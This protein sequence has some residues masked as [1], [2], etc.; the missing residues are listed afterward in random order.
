MRDPSLHIKK[1]DLIKVLN[2]VKYS[3]RTTGKKLVDEIFIQSQRYQ[4]KDRYLEVLDNKS[5][6]RKKMS[7]S[8]ESD[9]GAP[10][11][12][13]ETFNRSLVTVLMEDNMYRKQDLVTKGHKD[14]ILLKEIAKNAHEFCKHFDIASVK[15]G[16]EEY[17]R[18]GYG[19]MRRYSLNRFKYYDSKIYALFENKLIVL[20]DDNRTNT[21][22]YYNLWKEVMI[23][24][25][26]IDGFLDIENDYGKFAYIVLGRIE[27]DKNNAPYDEWIVAQFEG[28]SFLDQL[29]ELPQFSTEGSLDRY[30]KL[31]RNIKS[32]NDNESITELYD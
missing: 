32:N 5:K 27:A 17:V 16:C 11:K 7:R 23:E 20:Q 14:Y 28:L 13:V 12:I 1:S 21:M 3:S 18:M 10:D 30:V 29:P 31:K 8:Q 9:K 26:G 22:N 24:Y 4:I 2:E 25:S 19:M 6:L 15:E